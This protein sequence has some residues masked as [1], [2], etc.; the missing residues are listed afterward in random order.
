[1][2][3]T[4]EAGVE[5]DLSGLSSRSIKAVSKDWNSEAMFGGGMNS[6]LMRSPRDGKESNPGFPVF[7]LN[8]FPMGES[9]FPMNR[10]VDLVWA[11]I[12]IESEGEFNDPLVFF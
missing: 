3:E 7:D 12:D 10:V 11:M 1:M 4:Q 2:G 9:D 5:F 8:F 6:K